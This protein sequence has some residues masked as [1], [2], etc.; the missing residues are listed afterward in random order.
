MTLEELKKTIQEYQYFE[1]TN[2]IDVSIAS[3]V[4]TRLKI[5]DPVWL[6]IIGPSSGGKSQILRPIAMTD[7]K[8]LHRIDDLTENTFLSG[9]KL[10]KNK[11]D[12]TERQPSLLHRIGSKGMLVISDLTVIFSK[13]SESRATILSQFRMIYD[14]EM[15]KSSGASDKDNTW[16]GYLGVIAGSTPSIYHHFEEVSDMGERFVYYRMKDYDAEKATKISMS[17]KLYGRELDEKLGNA[18]AEYIKE[19]IV[20]AGDEPINLSE[21]VQDRIL[22]IAI[23][24]ERVRTTVHTDLRERIIDRL[25][26]PAMPMR[27]ALQLTTIAKALTIIRKHE[28]GSN[29]L[30][31]KDLDIIDHCGY[32]LANEEKRICLKVLGQIKYGEYLRTANIADE[33]GLNTKVVGTILQNLAAVGVVTRA[34][35][36][37]SLKWRIKKESD[38]KIVR[39]VEKIDDIIESAQRE[40]SY[41]EQTENDNILDEVF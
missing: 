3:V 26:V 16:K 28:T 6:V 39:R 35:D 29:D 8:F 24:S 17:R 4:A 31:D 21:E 23:F 41:E 33:V 7:P 37:E 14:G 11:Q 19:V 15:T 36:G 34:G 2:I 30:T 32:S 38:Y 25:P 5:G 1:D 9:M 12:G 18:Y 13:S 40:L 10:G 27:V 22:Q 20:S